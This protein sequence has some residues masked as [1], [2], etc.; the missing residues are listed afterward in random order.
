MTSMTVDVEGEDRLARTL[1]AAAHD[2]KELE[3]AD[4]AAG[5]LLAGRI[6]KHAPYDTGYLSK[7]VDST[8]QAGHVEVT[9]AARYAVYVV[10]TN[11]WVT[12]Q[13]DASVD[14]IARLYAE[15]VDDVLAQI[16][17]A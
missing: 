3:H 5:R 7:H 16:Q 15:D 17:G 1:D 2:L 14:D 10:A 13:V 6:S 8:V 12:R 9:I 4:R 11:P